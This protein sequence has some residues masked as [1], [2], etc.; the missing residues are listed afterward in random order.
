MAKRLTV[1]QHLR[2]ALVDFVKARETE[3]G[4]G[5]LDIQVIVEDVIR[6]LRARRAA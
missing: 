4:D 1:E 2:N 5:A 6:E 3:S